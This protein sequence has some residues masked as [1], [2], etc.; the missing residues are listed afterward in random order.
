MTKTKRH[1]ATSGVPMSFTSQECLVSS[2]GMV[3]LFFS[4]VAHMYLVAHPMGNR[5]RKVLQGRS[6]HVRT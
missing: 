1:H 6:C 2:V 3:F 4:T 5:I